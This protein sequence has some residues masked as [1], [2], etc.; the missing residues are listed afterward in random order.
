MNIPIAIEIEKGR[1]V[2]AHE[3]MQLSYIADRNI[4]YCCLWESSALGN[5]FIPII[6]KGI[7]A[8]R[9]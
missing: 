4:I 1:P 8:I 3:N 2:Y 5:P 7:V 9:T 6:S